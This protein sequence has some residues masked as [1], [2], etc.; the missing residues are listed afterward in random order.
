MSHQGILIV[1]CEVI[2]EII[3]PLPWVQLLPYIAVSSLL[4]CKPWV[5][6]PLT[7]LYFSFL[8]PWPWK[9]NNSAQSSQI[10]PNASSESAPCIYTVS[11]LH[12]QYFKCIIFCHNIF[13]ASTMRTP[14]TGLEQ[15]SY[16]VIRYIYK[17][18]LV[19]IRYGKLHYFN[20]FH[21]ELKEL[22]PNF[23]PSV[24]EFYGPSMKYSWNHFQPWLTFFLTAIAEGGP[25]ASDCA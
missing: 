4:C 20:L 16:K 15:K 24:V 19:F 13:T 22:H 1:N 6:S 12:L 8:L 18:I 11:T 9:E 23:F 2:V 7:R 21:I 5:F 14:D 3:K 25:W 10:S 17:I